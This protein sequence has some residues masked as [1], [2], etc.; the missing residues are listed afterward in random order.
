MPSLDAEKAFDQ[1][2]WFYSLAVL[3]INDINDYITTPMPKILLQRN[4]QCSV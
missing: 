2:E 1:V 4:D 3:D